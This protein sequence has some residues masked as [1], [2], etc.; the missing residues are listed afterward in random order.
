MFSRHILLFTLVSVL[1]ILSANSFPQGLDNLLDPISSIPDNDP[2]PN[3]RRI[4]ERNTAGS[5]D[6]SMNQEFNQGVTINR[7]FNRFTDLKFHEGSNDVDRSIPV[8]EITLVNSNPEMNGLTPTIDNAIIADDPIDRGPQLYSESCSKG[9][10]LACCFMSW[11]IVGGSWVEAE[12]CWWRRLFNKCLTP[13]VCCAPESHVSHPSAPNPEDRYE[14]DPKT[15]ENDKRAVPSPGPRPPGVGV[16]IEEPKVRSS[17]DPT[18]ERATQNQRF[19][20][21]TRHPINPPIKERDTEDSVDLMDK[22]LVGFSKDSVNQESTGVSDGSTNQDS[23]SSIPGC[24]PEL[25]NPRIENGDKSAV[26][27]DSGN[28]DATDF[29]SGQDSASFLDDSITQAPTG[30]S[31]ESMNPGVN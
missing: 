29:P 13:L 12:I 23:I 14:P 27:D 31:D 19:C 25:N 30:V 15:C 24:N 9:K 16:R 20:R 21:P 6:G 10:S 26:L 11:A 5:L 4:K 8:D 18:N 3:V 17:D 28:Q 2:N 7:N 1:I 22:N